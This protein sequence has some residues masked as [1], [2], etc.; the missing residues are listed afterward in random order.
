M[1]PYGFFGLMEMLLIIRNLSEPSVCCRGRLARAF[2]PKKH[3]P[4][5]IFRGIRTSRNNQNKR[6]F[7]FSCFVNVSQGY[8]GVLIIPKLLI[9]DSRSIAIFFLM[10]SG[11]S[12]VSL[13]FDPIN[14]LINGLFGSFMAY[15]LFI[16][17]CLWLTYGLFM[18]WMDLLT[19][20]WLINI[21]FG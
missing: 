12:K 15:L 18:D 13:N 21:N 10:M 16:M 9:N 2:F 14:W 17:A 20:L 6:F 5:V 7:D 4:Q 19:Y 8:L 1:I 3:P 11:T